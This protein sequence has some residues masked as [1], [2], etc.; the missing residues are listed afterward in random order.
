[1]RA[2]LQTT[3]R[4][5]Q[6][7]V[8]TNRILTVPGVTAKARRDQALYVYKQARCK[9]CDAKIGKTTSGGRT[10]YFCPRCQ[11]KLA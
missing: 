10:L 11:A 8:E 6:R 9:V 7:G 4:L 5:L 1:L 3:R 2:V